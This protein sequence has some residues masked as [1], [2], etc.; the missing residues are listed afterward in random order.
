MLV[1]T[2]GSI[3][4][5]SSWAVGT[6]GQAYGQYIGYSFAN[7]VHLS[8]GIKF[9]KIF[10]SSFLMSLGKV[11]GGIFGGIAGGTI[12]NYVANTLFGQRMDLDST[13]KEGIIGEIPSWLINIF[14]WVVL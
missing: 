9:S 13:I 8:S 4:G 10:S 12:S 14:R 7:T 11:A 2:I 6:I 1:A 5:A 3:T